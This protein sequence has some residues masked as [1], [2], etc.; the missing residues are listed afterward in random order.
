M[1]QTGGISVDK[2][3][4]FWSPVDPCV[5][6]FVESNSSLHDVS[7]K[8]PFIFACSNGIDGLVKEKCGEQ[9]V[10][11]NTENDMKGKGTAVFNLL[12]RMDVDVCVR[13]DVDAIVFD[14]PRLIRMASATGPAQLAGWQIKPK[15]IR[16]GC[17]ACGVDIIKRIEPLGDGANFDAAMSKN[18]LKMGGELIH[19]KLFEM[20]TTY[21]GECPVWH[22]KK[23]DKRALFEKHMEMWRFQN[24]STSSRIPD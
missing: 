9:A 2:K 24:G 12:R 5:E 14:L 1:V 22:P 6:Y 11:V 10:T 13:V 20:S 4:V 18:T 17:Q 21:T 16:G 23:N 7:R 15:R 3:I 8:Y 19:C